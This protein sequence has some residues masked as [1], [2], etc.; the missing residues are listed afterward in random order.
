MTDA[1]DSTQ[2]S[3]E[4]IL[5]SIR[6][7]EFDTE[8]HDIWF[9][10]NNVEQRLNDRNIERSYKTLESYIDAAVSEAAKRTLAISK[11]PE[12]YIAFS[13][14]LDSFFS[15]CECIL[16]DNSSRATDVESSKIFSSKKFEQLRR[17]MDRQIDA[18]KHLF[19]GRSEIEPTVK[20]N[21][22]G[23]GGRTPETNWDEIEAFVL[24][25]FP[26]GVPDVRRTKT[27][28]REFM[29]FWLEEQGRPLPSL[30]QLQR[31]A[32]EIYDKYQ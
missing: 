20:K 7:Q 12:A 24:E 14:R 4:D 17:Q 23:V 9:G 8:I 30:R 16:D 29:E 13:K 3:L 22:R 18:Y 1:K 27:Q 11:T 2:L 15:D 6:W 10:N 25:Q 26:N 21:K 28:I 32:S 19:S 5:P 31:K